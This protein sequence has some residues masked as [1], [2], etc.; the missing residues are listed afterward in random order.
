MKT[1][2]PVAYKR[3][4]FKL[5]YAPLSIY[6]ASFVLI[7]FVYL[8][9]Y[10]PV[11]QLVRDTVVVAGGK[12]Y[13]GLISNIGLFLWCASAAV[14][15]FTYFFIKE[16]SSLRQRN[17]VLGGALLSLFLLADDFLMMHE[18][19]FPKYLGINE[20]VFFVMYPLAIITFMLAFFKEILLSKVLLF[21]SALGFLGLSIISDK[22]LPQQGA[23]MI[24]E[25]GFKFIGITGWFLYFAHV[26][27][28]IIN[29][30]FA[31]EIAK[32]KIVFSD[33]YVDG[34][35]SQ[36]AGNAHDLEILK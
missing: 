15:L 10:I 30:I 19:F 21:F 33:L 9:P 26:C 7:L 23:I 34:K 8:Q 1:F 12:I 16:R 32:S 17:M 4:N 3:I 36:L 2:L 35:T 14:C 25:D 18:I 24:V 31:V 20:N 28:T 13:Y 22:I 11:E 5:G 29:K 27:H 6:L